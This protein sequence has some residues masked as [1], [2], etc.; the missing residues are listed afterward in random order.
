[1]Q[2][3]DGKAKH[4]THQTHHSP[5]DSWGHSAELFAAERNSAVCCLLERRRCTRS[6]PKQRRTSKN[7]SK[8]AA[9]TICLMTVTTV[10]VNLDRGTG[11]ARR[12]PV[13]S[14]LPASVE[15][16]A[17]AP[18]RNNGNNARIIEKWRR[19]QAFVE[20]P[21]RRVIS[22]TAGP[23]PLPCRNSRT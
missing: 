2:D 11:R 13:L 18:A 23:A 5:P 10:F 7:N 20:I 16:G 8:R 9:D 21:F 15:I 6:P 19:R 22:G 3:N 4:Q 1:M 17:R 14:P 12:R